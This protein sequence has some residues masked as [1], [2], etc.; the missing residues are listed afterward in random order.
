MSRTRTCLA[1]ISV[2]VVVACGSDKPFIPSPYT[3]PTDPTNVVPPGLVNLTFSPAAP[4]IGPGERVQ[5]KVI[6]HFTNASDRDVTSEATWTSSQTQV[7]TVSA[8]TVTGVALGR[9]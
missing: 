7:A 3:G 9:V 8:G 6:A 2:L 5:V 1:A 4:A